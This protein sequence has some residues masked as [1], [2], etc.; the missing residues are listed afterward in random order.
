MVHKPVARF[1]GG[2]TN[3]M[4]AEEFKT[5]SPNSLALKPQYKPISKKRSKH[6]WVIVDKNKENQPIIG[7]VMTKRTHIIDII[8]YKSSSKNEKQ[9][10]ERS[11]NKV[12]QKRL[13]NRVKRARTEKLIDISPWMKYSK[14]EMNLQLEPDYFVKQ[15]KESSILSKQVRSLWSRKEKIRVVIEEP[16]K[17]GG[18]ANVPT[19]VKQVM[20]KG[21]IFQPVWKGIEIECSPRK[22][23]KQLL[24]TA[25]RAEWTFN[26]GL[27]NE[28]HQKRIKKEEE[29]L[30]S[31]KEKLKQKDKIAL[32]LDK[33]REVF[34]PRDI[35]E[36]FLADKIGSSLKRINVSKNKAWDI[37][38][39]N[40]GITRGQKRKETKKRE[41]KR[42]KP[43]GEESINPEAGTEEKETVPNDKKPK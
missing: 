35:K 24:M 31:I 4:V 8:C 34:I 7:R 13:S 11:S 22:F 25:T 1:N 5:Q 39:K 43:E 41:K 27:Y 14:E 6:E 16:T 21:M 12:L 29:I 33:L 26:Q 28:I 32:G 17:K 42:R 37:A 20:T 18:E 10:G 3:N 15:E 40:S 19:R 36:G 38:E 30:K 9:T 2:E 23:I